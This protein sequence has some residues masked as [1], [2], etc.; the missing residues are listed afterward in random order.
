MQVNLATLWY[1]DGRL[2]AL[3]NEGKLDEASAVMGQVDGMLKELDPPPEWLLREVEVQ[4]T[5]LAALSR[6]EAE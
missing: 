1:E 4:A 6:Q 2:D 5:R 3:L